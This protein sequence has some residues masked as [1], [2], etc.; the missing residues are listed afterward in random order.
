VREEVGAERMHVLSI[1]SNQSNAHVHW[2]VVPLPPGTP[3]E[4]QQF[5]AV[6]LETAGARGG[7]RTKRRRPWPPV[8]GKGWRVLRWT[9]HNA[10][11]TPSGRGSPN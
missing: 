5:S 11:R 9:L 7:F 10:V 1:G 3:Y 4:G 6:R 8:A 2:H